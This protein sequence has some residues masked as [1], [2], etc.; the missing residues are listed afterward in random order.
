MGIG[1]LTKTVFRKP[2][3][4]SRKSLD[5]LTLKSIAK[6]TGFTILPRQ[7]DK[8]NQPGKGRRE[9]YLCGKQPRP[10]LQQ[11]RL[12]NSC[13]KT[14]FSDEELTELA[15]LIQAQQTQDTGANGNTASASTGNG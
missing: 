1:I 9:T 2:S 3:P 7:L 15:T 12:C 5:H 8:A 4:N 6:G 14:G 11:A 10:L 13:L